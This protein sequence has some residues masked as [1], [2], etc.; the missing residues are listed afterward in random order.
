M[1][2]EYPWKTK[3]ALLEVINV[4]S[5]RKIRWVLIGSTASYLHGLDIMPRDLDILV[6]LERVYEVDRLLASKFTIIRRVRQ[7]S[8][9]LYSSHY[10]IFKVH[11]IRVEVMADLKIRREYGTLKLDFDEIYLY[12]KRIKVDRIYIRLIPLEW[13]LVAYVMIPG[14]EKRVKAILALLRI[15]GVEEGALDSALQH[16][17]VSVKNVV[18]RLLR[19]SGLLN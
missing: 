4:L 16:A 14:R 17:P 2:R 6:D 13:Q 3:E 19:D 10:G 9:E 8:S 7:S 18:L 5:S 12:S 11:D 1:Q 15:R